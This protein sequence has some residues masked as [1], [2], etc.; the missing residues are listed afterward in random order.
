V[1]SV[2]HIYGDAVRVRDLYLAYAHMEIDIIERGELLGCFHPKTLHLEHPELVSANVYDQFDERCE[3]E[4]EE[5]FSFLKA[6]GKIQ[7]KGRLFLK[8][9]QDDTSDIIIT[10][11]KGLMERQAQEIDFGVHLLGREIVNLEQKKLEEAQKVDV[12]ITCIKVVN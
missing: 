2:L 6:G 9:E 4:A 8:A 1:G 12:D 5:R 10:D 11:D 7:V 3:K